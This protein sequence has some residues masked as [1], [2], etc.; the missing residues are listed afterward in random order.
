MFGCATFSAWGGKVTMWW[1]YPTHSSPP[2]AVPPSLQT[3]RE[4]YNKVRGNIFTIYNKE[5]VTR[6]EFTVY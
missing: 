2:F 5:K 4:G 6:K 3:W 1:Y